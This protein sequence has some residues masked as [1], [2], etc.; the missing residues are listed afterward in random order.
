MK[1]NRDVCIE[2]HTSWT[3]DVSKFKFIHLLLCPLE[4]KLCGSQGCSGHTHQPV[5][6]KPTGKLYFDLYI[7]VEKVRRQYLLLTTGM[8]SM[9]LF[10][11]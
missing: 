6:V 5:I 11:S 10:S 8:H 2:L 1:A 4:K 9:T 7:H 3:S